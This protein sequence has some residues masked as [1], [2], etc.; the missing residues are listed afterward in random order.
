MLTLFNRIE[1]PLIPVIAE[2]EA[3]GY[4]IDCS[5]F[6]S[7]KAKILGVQE[8]LEAQI[9]SIAG[10]ELNLASAIDL[11]KFI[12]GD[13]GLP[14]GEQTPSGK[15]STSKEALELLKGRHPSIELILEHKKVSKVISTYSSF[16]EKVCADSRLRPTYQQLGTV[17]GRLTASHGIQTIPKQ[18]IFSIRSGFIASEGHTIVA[19]DFDQQEMYILAGVSRDENL[20]QAIQEGQDLH[21]LAAKLVFGLDCPP[22]AVETLYKDLRDQVKAIQFGLIYGS[23]PASIGKTL[24]LKESESDELV[25]SYFSKFPRIRSYIDACHRS[26]IEHSCVTDLF[27][28]RRVFQKSISKADQSKAFRDSQNFPIQSAGAGITKLAMLKT[29]QHIKANH[30]S[31]K[32][33]LS[34]HDELQF[35]VPKNEVVHFANKLPGLMTD[36]GL[37][38]FGF[39]VPLK[40][41]VRA[42][43]D[44]ASL[45]KVSSLEVGC[46]Y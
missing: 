7:L 43:Q 37:D 36:L 31:I 1:L 17:T 38:T 46:V 35:E 4:M 26:L 5:F 25:E 27:G 10:R 34:L 9:R 20:L 40:V 16:P 30:P 18:D 28:R 21:G 8:E 33:I 41:K 13:L 12:Y 14:V 44:W 42:G 15:P 11:G 23:S 2:L 29:H 32:M 45:G 24:G 19:A 6:K 22:N 3:N 39:H